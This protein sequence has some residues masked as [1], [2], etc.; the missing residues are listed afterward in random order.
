MSENDPVTPSAQPATET[1]AVPPPHFEQP[2]SDHAHAAA[3]SV[4]V[5]RRSGWLWAG[6]LGGCLVVFLGAIFLLG[7]VLAFH[8]DGELKLG[9]H[10][11]AI[12]ALD[13]EIVDSREVIES[14]HKYAESTNV[15]GIVLRINSPGGAVAP[16]QEMFEEIR[17]LRARY[18]KPIVASVD[19]VAAS[20]GFYVAVA[21]DRIVANPGSITGSIGVI[22]QWMDVKDLLQWAKVKPE[23]IT[24]G[25]LKDAGS[26]YREMSDNERAY[27][28]RIV[29]QLRQQFVKAVA[30]GRG[31]KLSEAEVSSLADGRI[32]TGE[33]ALSLKLID[34]LGNLDDAVRLTGKLAGVDGTPSTIY[35]RKRTRGLFGL[36]GGND[37]EAASVIE[38]I[39]SRRAGRFLYRW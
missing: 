19:S 6:A 38:R 33:E 9:S 26:P 21:C 20:G 30:Q 29:L 25:A 27:F 34:Q 32:F 18:K 2:P 36:L 10:K 1:P 31:G 12:V 13:G 37:D 11:I 5:R 15:A 16:S 39:I 17:K 4:P 23:T 28:Q 35:P 22:M 7:L 8:D 3:A 24:S 14:L